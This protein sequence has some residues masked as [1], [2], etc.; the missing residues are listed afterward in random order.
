MPYY[1]FILFL[2]FST[3]A[4]AQYKGGS[5][6]GFLQLAVNNQNTLPNIYAGAANDGFVQAAVLNQNTLTN[7]YTGS[8]NDG[9]HQIAILNQN[10][11][12]N[13]YTG[14]SNDGHHQTS[15]INQNILPNIY[16]GGS[17][18]GFHQITILNQNT[19][20]NIYTGSS[21]DGFTSTIAVG[22]NSLCDGDIAIWNGSVSIAWENPANWD[23]GTLPGINSNV[24]IPPGLTRYPTVSFI[25]EIKSLYLHPGSS[26][27]ILPAVNFKLNGN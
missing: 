19:L 17:N 15:I 27:T 18:D 10:T 11:L 23:C 26:I 3:S 12:P 9:F 13:I 6:D 16:A 21:N 22:Q 20:P 7:I 5:N 4:A 14:G 8:S 1:I 2:F 24:I 25:Y